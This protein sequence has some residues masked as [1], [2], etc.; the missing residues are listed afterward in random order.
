MKA[1]DIMATENEYFYSNSFS[2]NLVEAI[3]ADGDPAMFRKKSGFMAFIKNVIS[4]TCILHQ[5]VS[6]S[7][8]LP[9]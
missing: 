4:S 5:H 6:A 7:R 3:R 1:A 8:T 2:W 9:S